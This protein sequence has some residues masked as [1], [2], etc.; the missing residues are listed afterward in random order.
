LGGA[1]C[2]GCGVWRPLG[3]GHLGRRHGLLAGLYHHRVQS[4]VD[5]CWGQTVRYALVADGSVLVRVLG[6]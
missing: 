2:A 5:P 3:V 1:K 4:V 6:S